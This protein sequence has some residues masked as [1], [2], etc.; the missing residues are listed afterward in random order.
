MILTCLLVSTNIEISAPGEDV[1]SSIPDSDTAYGSKSGTSMACPH[2]AGV[3]ALLLSVKPDLTFGEVRKALLEAVDTDL[4]SQNGVCGGIAG[5]LSKYFRSL[6]ML[7]SL[8]SANKFKMHTYF[9]FI[10]TV[11]PNH[12]HGFGRIN[13]LKLVQTAKASLKQ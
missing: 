8:R 5:M 1:R 10:D 13:A 2:A 11:F 9:Y 12:Y 4:T 3:T 6:I 7:K